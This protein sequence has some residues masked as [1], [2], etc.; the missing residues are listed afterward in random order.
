[1][2]LRLRRGTEG[3]R[4]AD[5]GVVFLEGELIYITDTKQLYAG[6]GTTPG[7]I[8]VTGNVNASPAILTQN[9]ALGGFEINGTGDIDIDGD[10][11]AD[12][13]TG[14]GSGLTNL[15]IPYDPLTQ[16]FSGNFSGDGSQLTNLPFSGGG[17]GDG[18]IA[19][20]TY[21][22]NIQGNVIGADSSIIIN[23]GNNTITADFFVG[24]VSQ[25]TGIDDALVG[26]ILNN[27]LETDGAVLA[28]NKTSGVF[29]GT[30]SGDGTQLTSLD[31]ATVTSAAEGA[32][33]NSNIID[34]DDNIILNK[35]T[36]TFAGTFNGT[37][38]GTFSGDG[39]GL[40]GV[41]AS[42]AGSS[43]DGETLKVNIRADD[44]SIAY[45]NV[46]NTFNGNFI[47]NG[48]G[49]T[50]LDQQVI[51]DALA[52]ETINT[53]IEDDLGN[54]IVNKTNGSFSGSFSGS[55][56]GTFN[57][58]H[59][60]DGS[61]LTGITPDPQA[62][63]GEQLTIY[64]LNNDSSI[65]YDF[66]TSTFSGT[67]NGTH[68]GDG[69]QLTNLN[70]DLVGSSQQISIV[71]A[72]GS[73]I[74]LDNLTET[75]S[76]T[77]NGTHVG[78][79]SGLTNIVAGNGVEEGSNYYINI[80]GADSA[81]L[82]DAD[83]GILFGDVQGD[84]VGSVFASDSTWMVD[85]NTGDMQMINGY[86]DKI[87]PRTSNLEIFQP[88]GLTQI[89][90]QTTENRNRLNLHTVSLT[91]DLVSTYTGFYGVINFGLDDQING[92]NNYGTIRGNIT[93]VRIGHDDNS[94]LISDE[95]KYLTNK[96]GDI[97]LGTYT[98]QAKLHVVGTGFFEE[99]VV[100]N[101][102]TTAERDAFSGVIAGLVLFNEDLQKLQL[103]V[104]D[105]GLAG[106]GAS[107]STAG[108]VDLN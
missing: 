12:T 76:G 8:R 23:S 56:S 92:L 30:F 97:G 47:G 14:S 42:V 87:I 90:M 98:P 24:D 66:V 77:F 106:G 44:S 86:I 81:T 84:V 95:T 70:V 94:G 1:M 75:F 18:V 50:A 29:T 21:E 15:P 71:S 96:N 22:I 89:F 33:L 60:G 6:D 57:G 59:V 7:G 78:D 2:T 62:L 55:H 51:V 68:V 40:T 80:N 19:G 83:L 72:D 34:D 41:I 108:W 54:I 39:S 35:T 20:E 37:H 5:G 104:D 105:T 64:L 27:S 31:T 107:N 17:G 102:Y 16:I 88:G 48:V 46:T 101:T 74:I 103:Y 52:D 69:S 13:F 61:A 85:A 11:T 25:T 82:L 79:G 38:T 99:G 100:Y 45:N 91:Q 26:V 43:L 65:A 28:F 9:M 93:D 63:N 4:T 10:I 3:Q 53:N 32:N 36:K 67:F 49:I 58:T 73:S